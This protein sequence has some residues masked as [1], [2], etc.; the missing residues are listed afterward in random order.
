MARIIEAQ[1]VISARDA[2]NGAFAS[3]AA[4]AARAALQIRQQL[5]NALPPE[6][7]R[8]IQEMQRQL[9]NIDHF[10]AMSRGLDEASIRMRQTAQEVSR[11]QASMNAAGRPSAE[12]AR[13]YQQAARA[14]EQAAQAFRA[15]GEAARAARQGLES[16]GIPVNRLA[17]EQARL[18]AA[19]DQ[20]NASLQRQGQL[21]RSAAQTGPWGPRPSGVT[22]SGVPAIPFQRDQQGRLVTDGQGRPVTA[23]S[24]TEA[25]TTLG[26]G[27][28]ATV[29]APAAAAM[30]PGYR[31]NL[32]FE[33]SLAMTGARGELSAADLETMRRNARSAAGIFTARQVAEMQREVVQAGMTPAQAVGM[34]RPLLDTALFGDMTPAQAAEGVISISSAYRRPM[35]TV[36]DARRETARIGDIVAY[37]ANISRANPYDVLQGFKYAAPLANLTGVSME[38]L[39]AMIAT[40]AQNGL[41]GDEAGVAI[42]SALVRGVRP[43]RDSIQQLA[44][45][46][47]S[48]IDFAATSRDFDP[49]NFLSGLRAAGLVTE[50]G[51]ADIGRYREQIGR[52]AAPHLQDRRGLGQ[53]LTD[54]YL[55]DYN[56]QASAQDRQRVATATQ[57][58]VMSLIENLD[59]DRLISELTNRRVTAGQM[60]R[61]F[62]VRQGARIA[63]M[64][65]EG[66]Q[67]PEFLRRMETESPGAAQRGARRAEQGLWGSHMRMQSSFESMALAVGESGV[68]EALTNVFTGITNAVNALAA[69]SPRLIEWSTYAVAAAATLGPLALAIAGL[70][71][72]AAAAATLLGIGGATAAGGAAAAGA[73]ASGGALGAAAAGA[74]AGGLAARA[75]R[76]GGIAGGLGLLGWQVVEE[77]RRRDPLGYAFGL[78]SGA[79]QQ[80]AAEREQAAE[81]QRVL[82]DQATSIRTP[83]Y[84]AMLDQRRRDAV[85]EFGPPVL[86]PAPVPVP[87]PHWSSAAMA[88]VALSP[89]A[90]PVPVAPQSV[91]VQGE[92]SVNVRGET[93]VQLNFNTA[94]FESMVTRIVTSA[95]ARMPLAGGGNRPGST[96]TTSPDAAAPAIGD[97]PV[98][99]GSF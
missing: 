10:R 95:V 45:M 51:D 50:R 30:M 44:E 20:T 21:A 17:A 22:P 37:A 38:R 27:A 35:A 66:S 91:Q 57:R 36:E 31:A 16:A 68:N 15:Q 62:D 67:Y 76:F 42:R 99:G 70:A 25:A 2:T 97:A 19:L 63:T 78:N 52:A 88:G 53:A 43:T 96:G 18:R 46:G 74:A 11:L 65:G 54:W 9:G 81:R 61:I 5:A 89:Q 83:A 69:T 82:V 26:V 34:T 87:Q 28:A 13:Q 58:H 60:S 39:G 12:L 23:R 55:N 84:Q 73:V 77:A 94:L 40:Q 6:T 75:L 86:P 8:R 92:A 24:R 41:R 64:L 85:G 98:T 80:R 7:V 49:A 14:A 29:T 3:A 47:L 93:V 4:N 56:P 1:A 72:A 33:R 32:E 48:P 59:V 79:E 71:R 90:V